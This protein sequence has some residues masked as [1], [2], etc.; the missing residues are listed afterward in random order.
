MIE[1]I[2]IFHILTCNIIR[3]N[4]FINVQL[5]IILCINIYNFQY[6]VRIGININSFLFSKTF[7]NIMHTFLRI[8]ARN[9]SMKGKI[10][11]N[12]LFSS[13]QVLYINIVS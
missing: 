5:I 4:K 10:K 2:L 9:K 3:I 6:N 1:L 11:H 7:Y 8:C 12:K 13:W